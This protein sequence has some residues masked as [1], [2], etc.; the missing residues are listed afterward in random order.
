MADLTYNSLLNTALRLYRAKEF[1]RAYE[2]VT[3]NANKVG[4][5]P[6][7][8]LN[9]RYSL[10]AAGGRNDPAL[11]IL[12]TAVE[13]G[14]WW[15]E[16][17]LMNDDDLAGLRE[18]REFLELVEVCRGRERRE[19]EEAISVCKVIESRQTKP[20]RRPFVVALH[21]NSESNS[22]SEPH[23]N[24]CL[25]AG[26]SLALVQSSTIK[27]SGGYS[28]D[29]PAEGSRVLQEHWNDLVGGGMDPERTVLG[30]FSAGGRVIMHALLGRKVDPKG[31]VLVG[32]W[33]P[34]LKEL[35]PLMGRELLEDRHFLIIVGDQDVDCFDCS[36]GLAKALEERGAS[37]RLHVE[38]GMEHEF[39]Q[40]FEGKLAT[41]LSEMLGNSAQAL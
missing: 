18:R 33:V 6:A 16:D 23:W 3:E 15:S 24:P 32:P 39:P 41:I 37:V 27:F 40:W 7:H 30:G 28:W 38:P 8:L 13:D 34:D 26:F 19:K 31:A 35:A 36:K 5:N 1:D 22:L 29:D 2:L 11:E 20:G 9:F 14:Y 25:P 12:T 21:G 10:A 17:I 4:G